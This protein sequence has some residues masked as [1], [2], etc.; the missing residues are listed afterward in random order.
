MFLEKGW[1]HVEPSWEMVNSSEFGGQYDRTLETAIKLKSFEIS[2][3]L[4]EH[5]PYHVGGP[6]VCA[7]LGSVGSPVIHLWVL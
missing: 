6:D 1:L 2:A 5:I 3:C 7:G 4:G